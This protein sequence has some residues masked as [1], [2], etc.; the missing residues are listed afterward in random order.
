VTQRTISTPLPSPDVRSARED[1][2]RTVAGAAAA[3]LVCT[4]VIGAL[5]FLGAGDHLPRRVRLDNVAGGGVLVLLV[6]VPACLFGLWPVDAATRRLPRAGRMAVFALVGAAA[7]ALAGAGF[8]AVRGAPLDG[9]LVGTFI[10]LLG[11]FA[12]F[13]GATWISRYRAAVLVLAA[14]TLAVVVYGTWRLQTF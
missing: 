2:W 13:V 14:L 3:I 6:V 10:G 1:A 4:A 7:G 8:A 11:G 12:G 9:A 5:T